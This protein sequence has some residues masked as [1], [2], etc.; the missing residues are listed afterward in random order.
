[1]LVM[2]AAKGQGTALARHLIAAPEIACGE[3]VRLFDTALPSALQKLQVQ[4]FRQWLFAEA[5]K[6]PPL[7]WVLQH[8][9]D[10]RMR[11]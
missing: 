10:H 1:M 8:D 3:L 9:L 5:G 4:A 2:A 11:R 7:G 6:Q